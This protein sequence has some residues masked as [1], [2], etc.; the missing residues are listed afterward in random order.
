[1]TGFLRRPWLW[2]VLT[3]VLAAGWLGRAY[4]EWRHLLARED[5]LVEEIGRLEAARATPAE[6]A[7]PLPEE[8]LP[9]LYRALVRLAEESGDELQSLTPGEGTVDLALKGPF[10]RLYRLLVRLPELPYPI[11]IQSY[12]L[13]PETPK[14]DRLDLALTL[15]VRLQTEA[16]A[17]NP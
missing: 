3:L 13:T 12:S 11:W 6:K 1:M 15:G 9:E 14:A 10:D 2:P 16:P 7:R 5:A 17:E 4:L 8:R